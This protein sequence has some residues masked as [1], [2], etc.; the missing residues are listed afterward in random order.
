M[1]VCVDIACFVCLMP[2]HNQKIKQALHTATDSVPSREELLEK[3]ILNVYAWPSVCVCVC[4]C[5]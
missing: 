4:V 2:K 3:A 1:C 5:V